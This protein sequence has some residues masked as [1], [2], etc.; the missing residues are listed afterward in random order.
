MTER[1]ATTTAMEQ[2]GGIRSR[3][4]AAVNA[5]LDCG[6]GMPRTDLSDHPKALSELARNIAGTIVECELRG[7][8]L[9]PPATEIARHPDF[10]V[11]LARRV[12]GGLH[13]HAALETSADAGVLAGL[14][15]RRLLLDGDVRD[16]RDLG[17][18][19]LDLASRSDVTYGELIL[20][21]LA[22]ALSGCGNGE[23]AEGIRDV[24]RV[25]GHDVESWRD[26]EAWAAAIPP[27]DDVEVDPWRA[28]PAVSKGRQAGL[29]TASCST[30]TPVAWADPGWIDA[31]ERF[32]LHR[33]RRLHGLTFHE[34]TLLL[35]ELEDDA[36]DKEWLVG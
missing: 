29:L 2:R 35:R 16:A 4:R 25:Q 19:A 14:V 7:S 30:T 8:K 28:G 26:I 33:H 15:A 20:G 18:L 9:G 22:A 21:V 12:L 17:V 23:Q 1:E 11:I 36:I 24:L 3:A 13:L 10:P 34:V 31:M 6:P 5:L 32:D 27:L